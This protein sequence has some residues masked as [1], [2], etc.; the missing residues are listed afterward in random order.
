MVLSDPGRAVPRD[1]GSVMIVV[2]G[3]AGR[4]PGTPGVRPG[5]SVTPVVVHKVTTQVLGCV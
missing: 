3:H 4:D 2:F 5:Q 1:A